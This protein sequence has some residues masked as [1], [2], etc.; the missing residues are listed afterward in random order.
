[1][2]R[3]VR[4]KMGSC[5]MLPEQAPYPDSEQVK[6]DTCVTCSQVERCTR[7]SNKSLLNFHI[8]PLTP[9][10]ARWC[11][12]LPHDSCK[13]IAKTEKVRDPVNWWLPQ[14]RGWQSLEQGMRRVEA[15]PLCFLLFCFP[16]QMND[17][18]SVYRKDKKNICKRVMGE[19]PNHHS[20][21]TPKTIA[22]LQWEV[23]ARYPSASQ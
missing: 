14:Q 6:C 22:T 13:S 12:W 1:M 21:T 23:V 5:R 2:S 8:V 18:M 3:R 20:T 17:N 11:E 10:L 9:S 4:F 16:N 15:N 19:S 7:Q